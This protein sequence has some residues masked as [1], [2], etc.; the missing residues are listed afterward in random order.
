MAA[1]VVSDSI[2]KAGLAQRWTVSSAGLHCCS[3]AR[4]SYEAS[5]AAAELGLDLS[6]HRS[7][8]M[9]DNLAASA[10]HILAMTSSL[11]QELAIRFPFARGKIATLGSFDSRRPGRDISDPFGGSL[12]IY[13]ECLNSISSC[14]EKF[15]KTLVSENSGNGTGS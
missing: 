11:A 6:A 5:A 7:R 13:R 12:K 10:T 9:T 3:G 8:P 2:R 15:V 1:A 4:A 14:A